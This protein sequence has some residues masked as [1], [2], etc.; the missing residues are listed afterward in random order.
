MENRKKE[1][2]GRLG[3][4]CQVSINEKQK[5]LDILER[6]EEE[7]EKNKNFSLLKLKSIR[8]FD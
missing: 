7:I 4:T 6:Q 2:L 3:E 1:I 5:Q 8:Y